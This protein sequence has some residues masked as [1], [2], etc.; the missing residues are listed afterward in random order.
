[1]ILIL[2]QHKI[3]IDGGAQALNNLAP[4]VPIIVITELLNDIQ[5]EREKNSYTF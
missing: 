4:D 2:K 5:K 3:E 1:M